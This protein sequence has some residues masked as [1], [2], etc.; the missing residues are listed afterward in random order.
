MAN[1]FNKSIRSD[2]AA[3]EWYASY[4]KKPPYD[5]AWKTIMRPG[6]IYSFRY[7]RPKHIDTLEYFDTDPLVLCLGHYKS[8]EGEII[9][10][11]LNLH[12]LPLQ[13]RKEVLITVFEM[14]RR[15][16]QG[17]MYTATPNGLDFVTWQKIK[18]P[19]RQYGASF[20]FRSYIPKLRT[21]P[22]FIPFEEFHNI[23]YV[24][25]RKYKG[26]AFEQLKVLWKQHVLKELQHVSSDR[27][28]SALTDRYI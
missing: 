27:L 15:H 11:G 13:V 24:P 2:R 14:F 28:A 5:L 26:I 16:Y 23:V 9:E 1:E 17:E 21:Q 25:S 22:I 19:L 20:A 8:K 7:H 18:E 6:M 12:F 3:L 4:V 10:Q